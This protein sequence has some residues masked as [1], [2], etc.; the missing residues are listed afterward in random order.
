MYKCVH[1]CI[2]PVIYIFSR[3]YY[4][5]SYLQYVKPPILLT[6]FNLSILLL[7]TY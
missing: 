7:H 3:F 4:N 6:V 5:S 2:Y 1:L